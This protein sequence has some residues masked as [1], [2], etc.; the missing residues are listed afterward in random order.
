MDLKN[1]SK[2]RDPR[3]EVPPSLNKNLQKPSTKTAQR[4]TFEDQLFDTSENPEKNLQKPTRKKIK[5]TYHSYK[6]TIENIKK[7]TTLQTKKSTKPS[8]FSPDDQQGQPAGATAQVYEGG[9]RRGSQL[10][11]DVPLEDSKGK[12]EDFVM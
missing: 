12:M 5:K 7:P 9:L 2:P 10:L 11:E 1:I 3:E 4:P 6:Q 8:S